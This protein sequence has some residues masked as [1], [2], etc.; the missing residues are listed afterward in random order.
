LDR[1]KDKVALITGAAGG[2]GAASA[3][4][5]AAEGAR[6]V[7][8]DIAEEAVRS[9]T[10]GIRQSGAEAIGVH[11]DVSDE[12]S[13]RN[14]IDVAVRTYGRLDV[15][16]NV[17]GGSAA[18]D[19]PV[20]EVDMR[21]WDK[22]L[23]VDLLGTFLF[24]RHAIPHMVEGGGGSI[25]NTSSWS[26]LRGFHKHVYVSAKGGL[27]SLTRAIAGEYARSGI[28]ANV[29]CPGGVRSER[30]IKRY[31]GM[32]D[33]GDPRVARRNRIKAEY[34]FASG[35]PIDIAYIALFLA[36]RESRMVTGAV[37][38]ADGGLSAY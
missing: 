24:C 14:A 15:L 13:V 6:V 27:L 20:H 10:D 11:A 22:T 26:A 38:A 16:F 2:I 8:V 30:N 21:L 7:L 23:S 4:L 33:P 28:R 35:D 3:A 1:L 37:I 17:A 36:S 12:A 29:I 31:Q 19:A 5:F 25:V 32:T 9:V 18:D 34:P